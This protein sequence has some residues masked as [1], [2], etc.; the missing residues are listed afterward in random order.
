MAAGLAAVL[1]A[2]ANAVETTYT[3]RPSWE[4][5]VG[6][7][8][9]F[10]VDFN[11]ATLGSFVGATYDAGPF[12]LEKTGSSTQTSFN[13]IRDAGGFGSTPVN[14]TRFAQLLVDS[15]DNEGGSN[16][17][18][19][20]VDLILDVAAAGW[21]ADFEQAHETTPE[22]VQVNLYDPS[23]TLI[24]TLDVLH[25]G[26]NGFWGFT[27]DHPTGV[28]R[29]EFFAPQTGSS[30]SGGNVHGM[31][32]VSAAAMLAVSDTPPTAAPTSV[33]DVGLAEMGSGTYSLVITY[34]DDNAIDVSTLGAPD[35]TISGP[36]GSLTVNSATPDVMSDGT[37]RVVTY[38]CTPPGGTWGFGDNGTYTVAMVGSQVEDDNSQAVAA[39]ATFATF[40]VLVGSGFATLFTNMTAFESAIG[41]AS[42]LDFMIDFE[43]FAADADFSNPAPPVNL[44]ATGPTVATLGQGAGGNNFA[45]FVDDLPFAGFPATHDVN[46]TNYALM[47][48]DNDE[49]NTVEL[50]F[51]TPVAAWG[52]M[53]VG[54]AD[55]ED[56]EIDLYDMG[57]TLLDSLEHDADGFYGFTSPSPGT[58]K[59]IVFKGKGG[60]LNNLFG[61]DDMKGAYT[62]MINLDPVIASV[63]APDVTIPDTG[64]TSYDIVIEYSDNSAIDVSTLDVSDITVTGPGAIGTLTVTG[65]TEPTGTDG[66]PRFATYT[67][68]PPGGAWDLADNGTYTIAINGGQV[69]DDTA[70][71]VA[72]DA[73]LETFVVE[74]RSNVVTDFTGKAAW[75]AAI[76][77]TPD[78]SEDF[79]GFATPNE[80]FSTTPVVSPT[81]GGGNFSIVRVGGSSTFGNFVDADPVFDFG[82]P[83]GPVPPNYAAIFVEADAGL[84]VEMTFDNPVLGWI[85]EFFT[86]IDEEDLEIEVHDAGGIIDL[87]DV[88]AN[89]FVG[90]T[91]PTATVTKLVF[92]G[93][94]PDLST[95][96]EIFGLDNICAHETPLG[97]EIDVTGNGM[98]IAGDGTN[99]PMA[100]DDTDFGSV[101]CGIDPDEVHTFTILNTGSELALTGTL[102]NL[103]ALTGSADFQVTQQPTTPVAA[104]TGMTTFDITFSP[105]SMGVKNAVVSIAN[106]DPDENPYTFNITGTGTDTTPPVIT[107]SGDNPFDVE[108]AIETFSDPGA[109]AADACDGDLTSSIVV[110]DAAVDESTIGVYNVTYNVTDAAGNMAS[111]V[112]RMVNVEDTTDPVI[113]GAKDIVV[114]APVGGPSDQVFY[115]LSVFDAC[116]LG[117]TI[118]C[119]PVNGSVFPLGTTTVNCTATDSSGNVGNASFDVI[120]L[121][122]QVTPQARSL[123]AL[124]LRGDGVSGAGVPGG[125][126]LFSVNKAY[127]NNNDEVIYDAQLLNAG[128]MNHAVITGPFNGPHAAIAVRNTASGVGN[129]G[130]FSN[131]ALNDFDDASFESLVTS[132][133]AQFI[134]E[135]GG[136][137]AVGAIKGGIASAVAG[138]PTWGTLQKP[139]LASNGQLLTN[140]NLLIG[141][142]AGV[143]IDDDTV[144]TSSRGTV[145]AREG[146]ASPIAATDY[147]Q[148]HPRIVTSEANNRYA[149][150]AHLL[151]AVF[152]PSDN[153]G[154]FLGTVSGA[155]V[156]ST[157]LALR[158]GAPA[159]GTGGGTFL[160]FL[161]E[162][163][164]NSG[165][166]VVRAT[167]AG[168][169]IFS[170]NDEGLWTN[171]GNTLIAREGDPAPCL[172][173][174]LLGLVAFDR[175]SSFS[176]ANDGSVC[177]HAF[178]K[179]ATATPVV[180]SANDGSIWRW[181]GG[182]LHLIARE[183]SSTNNTNAAIIKTIDN[184]EC[185]NNGGVVYQ[186]RY[187]D[188]VGDTTTVNNTGL[189]LDT[190]SGPAAELVLRRNDTF[191]LL[192]TSRTV[193]G[194]KVST[195]SNRGG[196]RGGYGRAISDDGDIILNLTLSGNTS[197]IF[198]LGAAGVE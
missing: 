100:G 146:S 55:Q 84:T 76:G 35:I 90:F 111:E 16:N 28:K 188:G 63:T 44:P 95:S 155:G 158:E 52:A 167:A 107:L 172:P 42:Q 106:D 174:P 108:C 150:S 72:A 163:V 18:D 132:N 184:Y 89:G 193:V 5:A 62:Y 73:S 91:L 129:Y 178:L 11:T 149:F 134:D 96:G 19:T 92:R 78:W 49:P 93:A 22:D 194:L 124:G 64:Q 54:G 180:N 152:D 3:S 47:W 48:V 154:L 116:D 182:Q 1:L 23:D 170:S 136:G 157:V 21:G 8:A 151:E 131:L 81:P 169:G 41:G 120:V 80:D 144:I 133:P 71:S 12:T 83:P 176:I 147:S 4:A 185:N 65:V 168:A 189:Y 141:S 177:F 88:N 56:L 192:G 119:N 38:E 187:L 15:L 103:V 59:R 156:G 30:G 142:G 122:R 160:Q 51:N 87:I 40:D 33:P 101:E 181:S 104:T 99:T 135:N 197:G 115:N 75:T 138:S 161:G 17:G 166:F 31:D 113:S 82:E 97:P 50:I 36:G 37:P 123:T 34:T 86:A 13:D 159:P 77:G 110:D 186:V 137:P 58:V 162:A 148:I 139:A 145:I 118:V 128:T 190:G 140:G 121:E 6:G 39:N 153:T 27:T 130:I 70:D 143:T 114:T 74:A 171:G 79:E 102:P 53:L 126:T 127:L 165:Q 26:T 61:M 60:P 25:L 125:A 195:E 43:D 198:V 117:V 112:I 164:N 46:G 109:T 105:S 66:T 173:A 10:T 67:V 20:K 179:N 175:F 24:A 69:F 32:N 183:G 196:G 45:N 85:G 9:D 191:T 14:G 94:A 29:I 57:G 2:Q 98:S 7:A 68:T